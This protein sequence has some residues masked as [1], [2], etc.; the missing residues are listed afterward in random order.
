MERQKGPGSLCLE[1]GHGTTQDSDGLNHDQPHF[2]QVM[3]VPARNVSKTSTWSE[4]RAYKVSMKISDASMRCRV[5]ALV[6]R[7]RARWDHGAVKMYDA[8]DVVT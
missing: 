7:T 5:M 1:S 8:D 3:G 4:S 2:L 6:V